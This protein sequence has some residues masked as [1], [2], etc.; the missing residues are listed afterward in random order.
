[1]IDEEDMTVFMSHCT[2][3][4]YVLINVYDSILAH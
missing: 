1:M 4:T 3:S 2:T